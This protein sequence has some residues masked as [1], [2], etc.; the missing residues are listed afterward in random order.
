M[1]ELRAQSTGITI[2]VGKEVPTNDVGVLERVIQELKS[3]KH[4]GGE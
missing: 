1:K 4:G 2:K 3:S